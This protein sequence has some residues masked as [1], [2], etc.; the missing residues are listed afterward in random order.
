MNIRTNLKTDI[1]RERSPS[2]SRINYLR[3]DKNERVSNFEKK[4]F[5]KKILTQIKHE[6]LTSYPEMEKIYNLI[7]KKNKINKDSIVLTAGSDG[8]RLSFELFTRPLDKIICHSLALTFAMVDIYSKIFNLRQLKVGYDKNL[9]LDYNKFYNFLKK[10][11][12]LVVF[13]NPNSPTGTL[14]EKKKF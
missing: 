13:A 1:Y 5:E 10:K 11:I 8:I 12:S 14:M 4:F 7:S 3:L 2:R 9:K 6:H